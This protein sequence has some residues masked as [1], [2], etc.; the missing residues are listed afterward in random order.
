MLKYRRSVLRCPVL[1][2]SGLDAHTT[3]LAGRWRTC[4]PRFLVTFYVL[5]KSKVLH[6][7]KH[8][9][10]YTCLFMFTHTCIYV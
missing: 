7:C 10:V 4:H 9:C 3:G 5:Y 8:I 6:I 1:Q 2:E